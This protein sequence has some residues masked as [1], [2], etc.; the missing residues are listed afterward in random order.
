MYGWP[1]FG[2]RFAI[3]ADLVFAMLPFFS[4][5]RFTLKRTSIY[6]RIHPHW[7]YFRLTVPVLHSGCR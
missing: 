6:L 7:Y 4:L 5:S 1:E 3:V 2:H